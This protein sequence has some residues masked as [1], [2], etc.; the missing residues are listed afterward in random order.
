MSG[1]PPTAS[2]DNMTVESLLFASPPPL[3]VE[4][5]RSRAPRQFRDCLHRKLRARIKFNV[6]LHNDR[7]VD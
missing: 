7:Q 5:V 2:A 1:R 6:A 3:A 4:A